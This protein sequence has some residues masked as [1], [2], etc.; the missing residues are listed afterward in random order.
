MEWELA[1]PTHTQVLTLKNCFVHF[2]N[3]DY[4]GGVARSRSVEARGTVGNI[5]K[6]FAERKHRAC[7]RTVSKEQGW[8]QH[9]AGGK[10]GDCRPVAPK[11]GRPGRMSA[12]VCVSGAAQRT[13]NK[14]SFRKK[15][16]DLPSEDSTLS[17]PGKANIFHQQRVR[18]V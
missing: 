11:E 18:V 3:I 9:H 6:W 13:W 14:S 15:V 1:D 16:H 17:S 2:R 10:M 5:L 8:K 12:L 4:K 7:T